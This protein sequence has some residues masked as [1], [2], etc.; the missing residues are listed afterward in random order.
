MRRFECPYLN[1]FVELT[2][3][4]RAHIERFHPELI[5]ELEARLTAVLSAPEEVRRDPRHG[6]TRL[7]STFFSDF[8]GGKHI[9]VAV[10]TDPPVTRDAPPRYWIVTAYPARELTQGVTEWKRD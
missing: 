5:L 1:G 7:F 9:V 3:E 10:V 8:R 4:R 2:E 6:A